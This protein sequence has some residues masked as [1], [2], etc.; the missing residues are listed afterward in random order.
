MVRLDGATDSAKIAHAAEILRSGGLVSFPTETVYGLGA[1]A[2]NPEALARLAR[3]KGKLDGKNYPLL[4][5][6]VRQAEEV[7]GGLSRIARKLARIYWPGPLTLVI[8]RSGGG[9]T[10]V[11]LPEHPVARSLLAQCRFPISAPN[12]TLRVRNPQPSRGTSGERQ[13]SRVLCEGL[14]AAQ[15]RATFD[16]HIDMILEG[17]PAPKGKLSTVVEVS[18]NSVTVQR[19]GSI[20]EIDVLHSAAPTILFVC[21]GN[22]CRSPMAA[23]L[24]R[25]ALVD[26]FRLD[27]APIR[28]LS[29]GTAAGAGHPAHPYAVAAMNEIGL[30]ISEH[31]TSQLTP[32]LVDSA[33]WIFTM[34]KQHRD[35]IIEFMPIAADRVRLISKDN[36]DIIE[37]GGR[38]VERYRRCR[39]KLASCL[40]HVLAIV[41]QS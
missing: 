31:R 29:A 18:E 1:D 30:N 26:Y 7:G 9:T 27:A 38:A 36:N 35:S 15:V 8:P 39:D 37:P 28:V 21:T 2:R 25:A 12:A 19:E 11:R 34:T 40:Q 6:S 32:E 41:D 20:R 33:D 5:S 4:V 16:G 23:G 24:C 13:P 22:T 14:T 10:G 3:I 17:N